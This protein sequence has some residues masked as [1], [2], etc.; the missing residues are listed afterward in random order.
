MECAAD[1]STVGATHSLHSA[2]AEINTRRVWLA[3]NALVV[4]LVVLQAVHNLQEPGSRVGLKHGPDRTHGPDCGGVHGLG[5][6]VLA[7]F[8]DLDYLVDER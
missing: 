1:V 7:Y 2:S 5:P 4:L 6:A 3:G 8:T